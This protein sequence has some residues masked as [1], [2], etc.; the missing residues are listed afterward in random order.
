MVPDDLDLEEQLAFLTEVLPLQPQ[1]VLDTGA[2]QWGFAWKLLERGYTAT[3]LDVDDEAIAQ[4]QAQDIPAVAAD[5]RSYDAA[6]FDVVLLSRSLHHMPQLAETVAHAHRLLRPGG[7]LVV[8]EFAHDA[9]DPP[10]ATWFYD[11]VKLLDEAT[12]EAGHHAHGESTQDPWARW[13]QHHSEE[14]ELHGGT[15]MLTEIEHVF[16]PVRVERGPYLFGYLCEWL[17]ETQAGYETAKSLLALERAY[18]RLG[19]MQPVG[20][21]VVAERGR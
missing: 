15:A 8:D 16:T 18:I 21:R 3:A 7:L 9:A 19:V 12:V 4:L 5:F 14:E 20:L 10:T 13:N 2:G 6:P 11:Q 1:R 17:P